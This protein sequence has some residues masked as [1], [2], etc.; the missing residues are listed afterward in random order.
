MKYDSQR[1]HRRSIRLKDYDYSQ[2][3]A[4][5]ITICAYNRACIF[6]DILEG[7]IKL[8]QYGEIVNLEWLKTNNMRTNLVLDAYIIMPNHIHGIISISDFDD[9]RGT[10]QRAPTFEHFGKPVSNSIPTIIRL[11]KSSVT[12]Q[13]NA[14]RGTLGL[15]V[16]QRNYYEHVIRNED[17][18]SE[19]REYILNNALKWDLDSENPKN[20]VYI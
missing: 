11:F 9:R 4:Y 10:L 19:I 6:G 16:W 17:D 5:F 20:L 18:L 15:P 7:Q 1:H 3:G 8:N 12:K 2:A 13:I 14:L